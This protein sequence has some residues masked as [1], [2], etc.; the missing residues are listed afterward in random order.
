MYASLQDAVF[1]DLRLTDATFYPVIYPFL[2]ISQ[3]ER[4]K[5]IG[6]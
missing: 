2:A 1:S 6:N 4:Q 5:I 3:D